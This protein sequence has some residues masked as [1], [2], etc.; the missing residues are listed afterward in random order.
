MADLVRTIIEGMLPDLTV[1]GKKRVFTKREIREIVKAREKAEYTFLRKNVTKK[2]YLKAI[3]YELDL[4][5][6][7]HCR[8]LQHLIRRDRDERKPKR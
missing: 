1:L 7:D 3:N 5:N 8:R 4:V 2:D 6:P